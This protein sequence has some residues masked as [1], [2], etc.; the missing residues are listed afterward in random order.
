MIVA[1]TQAMI[2]HS[3]H[4]TRSGS[5]PCVHV[6]G[7]RRRIH[8]INL[9]TQFLRDKLRHVKAERYKPAAI[10][11]DCAHAWIA[12]NRKRTCGRPRTLAQLFQHNQDV[13]N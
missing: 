7:K 5:H 2:S 9:G 4:L 11:S 13:V 3:P 10:R 6:V 8:E 1:T 12:N